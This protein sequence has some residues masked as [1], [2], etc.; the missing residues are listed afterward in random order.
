VNCHG[1][2]PTNPSVIGPK[3]RNLELHTAISISNRNNSS[4]KKK[5]KKKKKEKKQKK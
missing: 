4:Q 2:H 5:K 1:Q 3:S